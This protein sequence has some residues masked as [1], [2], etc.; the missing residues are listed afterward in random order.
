MAALPDGDCCS[1][2]VSEIVFSVR[3]FK[4]DIT[5]LQGLVLTFPL[6]PFERPP[7]SSFAFLLQS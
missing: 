3:F 6:F 1:P 4:T 2:S 5:H 7:V